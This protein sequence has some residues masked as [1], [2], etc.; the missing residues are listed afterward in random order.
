VAGGEA[1]YGIILAALC[2]Q[3]LDVLVTDRATAEALLVETDWQ[4]A[5]ER[6]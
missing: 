4:A 1:K 5:D 6:R 3:I 2:S